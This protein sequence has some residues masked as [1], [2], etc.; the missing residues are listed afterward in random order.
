MSNGQQRAAL[1]VMDYQAAMLGYIPEVTAN[2]LVAKANQAIGHARAQNIPVIFVRG[3]TVLPTI[4]H[5]L[6]SFGSQMC[7]Q[8]ASDRDVLRSASSAARVSRKANL[9]SRR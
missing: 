4:R 2:S 6:F 8:W 7:K 5:S 3:K 9:D 1:L